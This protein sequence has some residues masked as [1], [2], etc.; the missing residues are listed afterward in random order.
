MHSIWLDTLSV[1]AGFPD[2][3][4]PILEPRPDDQ[5]NGTSVVL[6]YRGA[7]VIDIPITDPAQADPDA[8][9]DARQYDAYGDPLVT[10]TIS[11]PNCPNYAMVN[12]LVEDF[13]NFIPT[14]FPDPNTTVWFDDI[15]DLD[16]ARYLQVRITFVSNAAT[17]L[18]PELSTLA[19]PFLK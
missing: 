15:N 7:S 14:H 4:D 8:W 1:N 2:Y 5:P 10:R 17:G 6:S 12:T 16:G 9:L 13:A 11:G 18:T 3:S 19:I